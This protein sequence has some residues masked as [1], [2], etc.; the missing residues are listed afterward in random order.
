M[1]PLT[2]AQV[3]ER[4]RVKSGVLS[5]FQYIVAVDTSQSM[6]TW[7]VLDRDQFQADPPGITAATRM[8]PQN[9]KHPSFI[10]LRGKGNPVVRYIFARVEKGCTKSFV[11]RELDLGPAKYM[12]EKMKD[13]SVGLEAYLQTCNEYIEPLYVNRSFAKARGFYESRAL[14]TRSGQGDLPISAPSGIDDDDEV[15]V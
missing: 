3:K 2:E 7:E 8:A 6:P 9:R 5:D 13:G 12:K 10:N 1:K 14:S 11:R 15:E 4:A